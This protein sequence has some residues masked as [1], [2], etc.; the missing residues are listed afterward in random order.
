M[1]HSRDSGGESGQ[2]FAR[3]RRSRSR[4]PVRCS[5]TARAHGRHS[6][7]RGPRTR[8]AWYGGYAT[9]DEH[10]AVPAD[11]ARGRRAPADAGHPAPTATPDHAQ[12]GSSGAP[13]GRSP[14]PVPRVT[15]SSRSSGHPETEKLLFWVYD[16]LHCPK[17]LSP[18][19]EDIGGWWLSCDHMFRRFG[20]PFATDWIYKNVNGY[21]YTAAIPAE[22]GLDVGDAGVQL[23]DPPDRPRGRR[24]RRQDRRL[25]RRRPA[26]LRPQL[27]GVVARRASSP[28][29]TATSPTSRACSTRRTS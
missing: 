12:G 7:R 5:S 16:D 19:Y 10:H 3:P 8:S 27:R 2:H 23:P 25:P 13:Q 11:Q 29:C 15:T 18:M 22:A 20:T 1:V 17:P 9:S 24:V 26:R 14:R 6:R 4:T 28:R 21:L